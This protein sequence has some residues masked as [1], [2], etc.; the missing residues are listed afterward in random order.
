MV[1]ITSGLHVKK[2]KSFGSNLIKE[3]NWVKGSSLKNALFKY[4]FSERAIMKYPPDSP[5][6]EFW[7]VCPNFL[8][9]KSKLISYLHADNF[10]R[11]C[12]LDSSCFVF[13]TFDGPCGKI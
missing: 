3:I 12:A 4:E 10:S 5:F 8:S 7:Q 9:S 2:M 1:K 13:Y 11:I 6:V